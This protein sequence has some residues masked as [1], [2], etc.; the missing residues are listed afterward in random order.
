MWI[1]TSTI[2]MWIFTSTHTIHIDVNTSTIHMWIFTLH[3]C[4]TIHMWIFTSTIHMWIFTSTHRLFTCEYSHWALKAQVN[5]KSD[6]AD[7]VKYSL[8]HLECRFIWSVVSSF[9]IL[10]RWSSYLGLFYHVPLKREQGDRDWRLRLEDTPNAM[11]CITC[12]AYPC[13]STGLFCKRAL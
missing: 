13:R 9:L 2:H 6:Y 10:N 5:P 4:V 1:F 3:S 11:G 12:R 7:Q 8:L